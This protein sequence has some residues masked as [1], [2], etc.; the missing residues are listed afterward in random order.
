YK[1]FDGIRMR[2]QDNAG[3][4]S[5]PDLALFNQLIKKGNTCIASYLETEE[6][7]FQICLRCY[8]T[9]DVKGLNNLEKYKK[10]YVLVIGNS[11]KLNHMSRQYVDEILKIK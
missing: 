10:A 11:L 7:P 8:K 4:S 5:S 1:L 9:E 3:A 6:R 2:Q